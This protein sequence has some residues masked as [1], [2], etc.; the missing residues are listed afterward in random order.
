MSYDFKRL[1]DVE[2]IDTIP[3]DAEL[4]CVVN[5]EVKKVSKNGLGIK[6]EDGTINSEEYG[7]IYLRYPDEDDMEIITEVNY[8][9]P[10]SLCEFYDIVLGFV[11]DP[12]SN[13][14]ELYNILRDVYYDE[15]IHMAY[16]KNGEEEVY[17]IEMTKNSQTTYVSYNICIKF[18]IGNREVIFSVNWDKR[19]DTY[20]FSLLDDFIEL[21]DELDSNGS[22]YRVE[23]YGKLTDEYIEKYKII[24]F[25]FE[26]QEYEN[27]NGNIIED[28]YGVFVFEDDFFYNSVFKRY[29][30]GGKVVFVNTDYDDEGNKIDSHFYDNFGMYEN[31]E[32]YY[33]YEYIIMST[34]LGKVNTNDE[35]SIYELAGLLTG[36][37]GLEM[38]TENEELISELKEL[39]FEN[40][41]NTEGFETTPLI[42]KSLADAWGIDYE[43]IK[44]NY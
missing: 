5:D 44:T 37:F 2:T 10:I 39:I 30:N 6:A 29:L 40:Y 26:I 41:R 22:I 18:G 34:D 38:N 11:D 14:E 9:E 23:E 19:Y 15:D 35:I 16:I 43:H 20:S 17:P 31:I 12:E 42:P 24:G 28:Y 36:L 21:Y 7:A 4:F 3:D 33:N 1:T 32:S 27:D 13:P 25:N 8:D